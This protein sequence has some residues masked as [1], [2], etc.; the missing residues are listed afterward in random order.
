MEFKSVSFIFHS[1]M[2]DKYNTIMYVET[3]KL[4]ILIVLDILIKIIAP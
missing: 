3:E 2:H 1:T 4:L